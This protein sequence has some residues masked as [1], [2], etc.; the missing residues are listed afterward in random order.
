MDQVLLYVLWIYTAG[1]LIEYVARV[2]KG[3]PQYFRHG[4]LNLAI[5]VGF[6][7][8]S[9]VSQIYVAQ[10]MAAFNAFTL[11]E[12]PRA[13]SALIRGQSAPWWIFI[14]LIVVEDFVFYIFHR[15]SHR[16]KLFWSAHET[17]HS[18]PVYNYT[19]SLRLTWTGPFFHWIFW[20]PMVILGFNPEDI[21]IQTLINGTVQFLMHTELVR[22]FGPLDLIFNSPSHHRVHHG[23]NPQYID[24]NYAGIF[25]VWDRMFGTFEPEVAKP[26]YGVKDDVHSWNPIYLA[27]RL[28]AK[29]VVEA[30]AQRKSIDKLRYVFRPPEWQ[31]EDIKRE[32]PY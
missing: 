25:I 26:D 23:R 29:L 13:W 8:A 10:A 5:A 24:K 18:S 3:E 31:P 2:L 30:A 16:T 20:I 17:H 14:V 7:V 22:S 21:A 9:G 28:S 19:T 11:F 15:V 27:L 1:V 32:T 12:M 4:L 6:I